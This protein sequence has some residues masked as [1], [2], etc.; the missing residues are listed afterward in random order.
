[1]DYYRIKPKPNRVESSTVLGMESRKTVYIPLYRREGRGR[2][3]VIQDRLTRWVTFVV[4]FVEDKSVV[5]E[6][7]R[8]D[9]EN[10]RMERRYR[11]TTPILLCL[12]TESDYVIFSSWELFYHTLY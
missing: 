6:F 9:L 7:P 10:P 3:P 2:G 8:L 12:S 11:L 5:R 1:M 4:V